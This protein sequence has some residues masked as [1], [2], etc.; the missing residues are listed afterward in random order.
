MANLTYKRANNIEKVLVDVETL[1]RAM[2]NWFV[3]SG[4]SK[5]GQNRLW[6]NRFRRK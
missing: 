3:Y 6:Q 5:S 1:I 4:V 2:E